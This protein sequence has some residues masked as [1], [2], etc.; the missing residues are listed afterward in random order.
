MLT[1]Y[2]SGM[3][4]Y[5]NPLTG[6][7]DGAYG[8]RIMAFRETVNQLDLTYHRL[9]FDHDTRRAIIVL[10]DPAKDWN[11]ES[12]DIPCNVA[13]HFMI[14]NQR[15][16]MTTFL[17]SQDMFL[18]FV[19]DTEEWQLLMELLAGWLGI[20]VGT[21]THI[22][23]S[24]HLYENDIPAAREIHDEDCDFYSTTAPIDARITREETRRFFPL[25]YRVEENTRCGEFDNLELEKITNEFWKSAG[26]AIAAFNA[27]RLKERKRLDLFSELLSHVSGDLRE[28]LRLWVPGN[29]T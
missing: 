7:M 29:P 3:Q 11:E 16:N 2:A 20:D 9:R 22:I 14:R 13:L 18:G 15:L 26:Y 24:A 27:L 21:Y 28:R 8:R 19:Y 4:Q 23:S 5:A 1:H 10:Y 12:R 17:R 6:K 25:L